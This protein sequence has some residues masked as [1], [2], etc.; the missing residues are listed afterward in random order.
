MAPKVSKIRV[1]SAYDDDTEDEA[2]SSRMV[3]RQ[4]S[5]L[6]SRFFQLVSSIGYGLVN[7]YSLPIELQLDNICNLVDIKLD[8][9]ARADDTC[10]FIRLARQNAQTLQSLCIVSWKEEVDIAAL[11]QYANG[12]LVTYPCLRKLQLHGL[13]DVTISRYQEFLGAVPFPNLRSL[14]VK[15]VYPFSDDTLFRGNA[16]TLEV[17]EIQLTRSMISMLRKYSVFTPASHPK[18]QCVNIRYFDKFTPDAFASMAAVAQFSLSIGPKA[19]VRLF[20]GVHSI[21]ELLPSPLSLGGHL[22]I[23]VLSIS[24]VTLGLVD[25]IALIKSLPLLTDLHVTSLDYG[26]APASVAMAHSY[27]SSTPISKRFRCLLFA[28]SKRVPY[29]DT[30]VCVLLLALV[31]PSL[32]YVAPANYKNKQFMKLIKVHI[33]SDMFKPYALRLQR[34]LF[35]GWRGGRK[36]TTDTDRFTD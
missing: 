24:S 25:A 15:C 16:A 31:C 9:M 5:D 36:A 2:D 28:F 35:Y 29:A 23:Q 30:V 21:D 34:L 27:A 12:R 13:S 17:L 33:A 18:L 14:L 19:P 11:V 4:F 20:P 22:L 10:Q 7:S 6:V 32:G 3:N 26:P 8:S 1:Q